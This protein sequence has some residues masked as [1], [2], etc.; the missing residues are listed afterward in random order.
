VAREGK[1]EKKELQRGLK[2]LEQANLL[3]VVLNSC[4]SADH[5]NYYQRYG[6]A[7]ATPQNGN[8]RVE[9]QS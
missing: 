4:S 6:N 1:T 2:A 3:G 7:G 9:E 8:G 5:S